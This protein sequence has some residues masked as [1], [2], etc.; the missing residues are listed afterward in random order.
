MKLHRIAVACLALCLVGSAVPFADAGEISSIVANAVEFSGTCGE[1]A[2]WS[3]DSETAT[4]TV[5][6]TGIVLPSLWEGYDEMRGL[7][8]RLIITNGITSIGDGAFA[9]CVNL[10]EVVLPAGMSGIGNGVFS[11]CIGLTSIRIPDSVTDI[12]SEHFILAQR[13]RK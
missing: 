1:N 2:V 10:R 3:F 11:S 8:E 12:G 9:G 13:C 5:S 7:V 4:L 6:G